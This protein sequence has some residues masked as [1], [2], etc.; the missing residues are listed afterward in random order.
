[1]SQ[2]PKITSDDVLN[3]VAG[4]AKK[5]RP[6]AEIQAE[7]DAAKA[8]HRKLMPQVEAEREKERRS[9]ERIEKAKLQWKTLHPDEPFDPDAFSIPMREYKAPAALYDDFHQLHYTIA[10]LETELSAAAK[11]R[12]AGVK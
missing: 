2:Q 7:L 10:D 4:V 8:Q 6:Q 11:A 9:R 12:A 5:H 3:A 1:M